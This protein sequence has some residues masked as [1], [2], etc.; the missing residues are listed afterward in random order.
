MPQISNSS[1][2]HNSFIFIGKN[3]E[4]MVTV[5]VFPPGGNFEIMVTVTIIVHCMLG[6]VLFETWSLRVIGSAVLSKTP[7]PGC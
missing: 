6:A 2:R 3:F 7:S 4:V 1:T 5:T